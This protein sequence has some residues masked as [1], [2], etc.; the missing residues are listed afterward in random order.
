MGLGLL[1]SRLM[2]EGP[3]VKDKASFMVAGRRSYQDVLL[4]ASPN[5][6]FNNIIANFYD[7]NAKVNYKFSDKSRLFL[8]AYYGKDA[9]G[10]PG[11]VSLTGGT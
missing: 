3:I 7:L 5:D 10:V 9:F 1:S 8:S 6:D 11:L 4:K 2:F